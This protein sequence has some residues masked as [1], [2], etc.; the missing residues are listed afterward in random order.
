MPDTVLVHVD[1]SPRVAVRLQIAQAL[2]HR[3]GGTAAALY[4]VSSALTRYPM[5]M[6]AG[7]DMAPLLVEVDEQRLRTAKAL[8][9]QSMPGG[10]MAW[11]R[12]FDLPVRDIVR[13]ALYADVLVLGQ[14]GPDPDADV[15]VP[16]DFVPSVV[17]GSGK[18]VLVVP[19]ITTPDWQGRRALVAWKESRESAHAVAAAL[20]LLRQADEVQVVSFEDPNAD[21]DLA[22]TDGLPGILDYLKAHGVTATLQ[23]EA[24]PPRDL[25]EVLLSLA[26]DQ[27]S[28]LLVMGCYGH[29]RAR[30]WAL[31]GVTRTILAAMTLPVLM[32]H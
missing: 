32:A 10:A 14:R 1:S 26:A 27:R 17:L 21:A 8:F 2:A 31:G 24:A 20:P 22:P 28:D 25:G 15:D 30:E 5:A 16:A 23:H 29:G 12:G 18:P 11:R 7:A 4:G 13:H 19:H 9:D 3:L 6:A